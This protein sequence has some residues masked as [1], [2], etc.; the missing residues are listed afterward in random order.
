M[1][2]I[3][4][5]AADGVVLS[6]KGASVIGVPRDGCPFP[7]AAGIADEISISIQNGFIDYNV[8]C[9]NAVGTHIL[10][11]VRKGAIDQSCKPVQLSGVGNLIRSVCIQYRCL[12]RIAPLTEAVVI[13]AVTKHLAANRSASSVLIASQRA[14]DL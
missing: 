1:S 11:H 6:V 14:Q 5:Q 7:Q 12:I 3:K 8:R 13:V 9:Q 10:I 4:I 2:I